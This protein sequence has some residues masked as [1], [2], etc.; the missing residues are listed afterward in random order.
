V[1]KKII[2]A[3]FI[4]LLFGAGILAYLGQREKREK[5]LFYSGTIEATEADLSFQVSGRVSVIYADEGQAVQEGQ[6]LAEIDKTEFEAR[7][8]AA[9]A[10]LELAEINHVRARLSLEISKKT[11]PLDVERAQA[12]VEALKAK[13]DELKTGFRQ[14]EIKQARLSLSALKAA[15]KES[16]K[17]RQRYETL[18]KKGIV[19]EK[20]YDLAL[21]KYETTLKD[22]ERA[23][24][25]V[26][27]LEE[28][29][30]SEDIRSL[31]AQLAEREAMLGQARANLRH[32]EMRQQ[33]MESA[34]AQVRAAEANL[35]LAR[36]QWQQ[37]ELKSPRKGI[38]TTRSITAGE[39][40]LP[41]RIAMTLADL[42]VVDLKIFVAE[43]EIGHIKPDQK[44]EVRVDSFPNRS[45]GGR[46]AY[47][48]PQAEFTPKIIQTRQERVKLV[49]LVKVQ[50][51]NPDLDLKPGMPADAWLI[52][53]GQKKRVKG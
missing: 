53:G 27:L 36:T 45:F 14:Q 51:P 25:Q 43:T 30:R 29:F 42:S 15:L 32:I 39:V 48:S 21:L 1:K 17:N 47:I 52:D 20:E 41:N 8:E 23:R 6:V 24:E 12:G 40:A 26:D 3:V 28:G 22:Y 34:L 35:N 16:E 4:V 33:D 46:V 37:T 18:F 11:L 5:E 19:S 44:V 50:I 9:R 31:Q 13:L 10:N 2:I 49:Y 38:V 7:Y